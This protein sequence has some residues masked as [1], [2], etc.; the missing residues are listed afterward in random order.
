MYQVWEET[1]THSIV[2][3]FLNND[4]TPVSTLIPCEQ[5]LDVG[6]LTI[7]LRLTGNPFTVVGLAWLC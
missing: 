5:V 3:A 6:V 1:V 4:S 7:A 2:S